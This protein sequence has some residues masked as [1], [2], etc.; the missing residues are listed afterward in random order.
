MNKVILRLKLQ[1]INDLLHEIMEETIETSDLIDEDDDHG[2]NLDYFY[3]CLIVTIWVV[4][5]FISCRTF[6]QVL[7][8]ANLQRRANRNPDLWR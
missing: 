7:S 5:I 4:I 8:F 1:K 3:T 6:H 2:N